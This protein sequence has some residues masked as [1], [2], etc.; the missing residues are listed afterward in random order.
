MSC[1]HCMHCLCG[2][3]KADILLREAVR[4]YLEVYDATYGAA[5]EFLFVGLAKRKTALAALREAMNTYWIVDAADSVLLYWTDGGWT[6]N[7]KEAKI[8]GTKGDAEKEW[9]DFVSIQSNTAIIAVV[10]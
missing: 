5:P 9:K 2:G 8:F 6:I 4:D 3:S 10:K 1:S 7:S